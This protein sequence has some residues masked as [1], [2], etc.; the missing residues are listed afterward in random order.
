MT[1]EATDPTGAVVIYTS[2]TT[3]DAVDGAG[4]ATCTPLSNTTFPMAET[5][6]T[7]NATDAN[8]NTATSTTFAITVSD[9]T[10]P[11]I[12]SHSN[13]TA[14]ATSAAGAVVIYTSPTTSDVVDGAGVATCSP[15]S[16][17]TFPIATTTITC[18]ATDANGNTA[19]STTFTITVSD[20]TKP[21]IASHANM[22]AEATGPTG[23]V[24]IYTSPTTSDAVDGAGVATCSPASNSTFP[25]ATTTVTCNA[26]DASGNQATSTTFTITVSDTT[27]P[28]IASHSNLIVEATGPTGAVV[29]LSLIHI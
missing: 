25:I 27:K 12:A 5:T 14:E 9:T 17:T 21:V 16:N 8:G 19:T 24:V 22:T 18:N 4:V 26:T 3:S 13:L 1:A 23:A 7:C 11:V 15:A 20:T 6:V 2:P 10:K 28:V 29:I